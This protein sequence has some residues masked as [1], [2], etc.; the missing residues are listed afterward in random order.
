MNSMKLSQEKP[1]HEKFHNFSL[2]PQLWLLSASGSSGVLA[3]Q[4]CQVTVVRPS[5]GTGASQTITAISCLL[6]SEDEQRAQFWPTLSGDSAPHC[7][8]TAVPPLL[9]YSFPQSYGSYL[10]SSEEREVPELA[11]LF[12]GVDSRKVAE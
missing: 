12:G 6:C 5:L 9:L 4:N 1:G 2:L 8:T 11:F 10:S 7:S 3:E